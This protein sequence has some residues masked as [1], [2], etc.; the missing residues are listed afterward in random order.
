MVRSLADRTF[1]LRS[2]L[3]A[4]VDDRVEA[5]HRGLHEGEPGGGAEEGALHGLLELPVVRQAQEIPPSDETYAYSNRFL[6]FG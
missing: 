2:V 4:R 6:I 3:A 5:L 1:Q